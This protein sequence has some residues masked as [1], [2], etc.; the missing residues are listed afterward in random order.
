MAPQHGSVKASSSISSTLLLL[1]GLTVSYAQLPATPYRNIPI[2]NTG[3]PEETSIVVNPH[4]PRHMVAGA[5]IAWFYYSTNGGLTWW[6]GALSSP[7]TVWGDPCVVVDTN[8]CYYFFHL[9]SSLDRIVCQKLT[10]PGA[11]WSPGTYTGL[12]GTKDQDKAW[13]AVDRANNNIYVT[14]TQFD[15]YASTSPTNF[16]NIL[17]SRST[18]G[19]M[20][21][22]VPVRINEV[23]GDCRDS[24]STVEGAVPTVGPGGEIYVAWAGPAGLVC[25]KSLDGGVT[26]PATNVFVSDIPGGWDFFIP[27]IYRCNGL[28]V[29]ACDL[30]P[31]PH[32]G[33]VYINW[34]DQRNGATDTDIWLTKSTDGGL[35][36]STRKRVND[37][38]PGRQQFFTWMT[39]DQSDGTIYVV[40]YDR[41]NYLDTRTDVYLACSKDGGETFV[42]TRISESPF[43]P[44]STT[45]FGDYTGISAHNG[46]VRPIWTRLD[47]NALSIWTALIDPPPGFQNVSVS[48][49]FVRLAVTNLT[50]YLINYILRSTDL[51]S[52]NSWTNV[53]VITG[54]DGASQWSE[55]LPATKAFYRIRSY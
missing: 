33:T 15:Q 50:S 37:D 25:T 44:L 39:V 53:G 3:S 43:T 34:S 36:W 42:N 16:S 5:N 22:S 6:S 27:G 21:W 10:A 1:A 13:A 52:T 45:F 28:P 55:P 14:W 38:P 24:D 19:G 8:D 23:A 46:V 51:A 18:D 40:F 35:T 31:G 7:Y 49:D 30:G 54:I 29:T 2:S 9:T 26:W 4:N 17:F 48:N 41:R 32:R 20:T 47:G 11:A 12:N